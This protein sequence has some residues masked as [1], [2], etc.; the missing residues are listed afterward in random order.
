M[1]RGSGVPVTPRREVTEGSS[2]DDAGGRVTL[3]GDPSS[4]HSSGDAGLSR[5]RLAWRQLRPSESSQLHGL[6]WPLPELAK[7]V[8]VRGLRR[9]NPV[10]PAQMARQETILPH[11]AFPHHRERR[12]SPRRG[13][14]WR[15]DSPIRQPPS[16]HTPG[17][18]PAHRQDRLP[19]FHER[20]LHVG[21]NFILSHIRRHFWI[22]HGR[23]GMKRVGRS[24]PKCVQER[25][26]PATQLMGDLPREW[27]A[28]LEPAFTIT[29]VD[30]FGP[31][32]VS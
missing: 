24:C 26:Q 8:P 22:V 5:S 13:Q 2:L 32:V 9:R 18:T 11:R 12:S 23:Q 17:Q 3:Q 19:R 10:S 20:L 15:R 16:D 7:A 25:A 1:V 27:L 4:P 14:D 31:F 28:A 30:Y 29:A 6:S 21:V